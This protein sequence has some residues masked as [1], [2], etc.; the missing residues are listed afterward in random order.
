MTTRLIISIEQS[1]APRP[2][3]PALKPPNAF[4][5]ALDRG[6]DLVMAGFVAFGAVALT[7]MSILVMMIVIIARSGAGK[8]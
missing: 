6:A 3:H 7:L 4:L 8:H 2:G 5:Q 1:N